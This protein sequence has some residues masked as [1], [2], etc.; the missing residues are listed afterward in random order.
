MP[1][2]PWGISAGSAN[3]VFH[4]VE[5]LLLASPLA[6]FLGL[7]Y[8]RATVV[9][10][11]VVL[12]LVTPVP[13]MLQTRAIAVEV[14]GRTGHVLWNMRVDFLALFIDR[15]RCNTCR[16]KTGAN[17]WTTGTA[18]ALFSTAYLK[19][20]HSQRNTRDVIRRFG[21]LKALTERQAHAAPTRF[22]RLFELLGA[23]VFFMALEH[24]VR[25][26]HLALFLSLLFPP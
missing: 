3:R 2:P 7:E 9:R 24:G 1:Y 22:A 20:K 8:F 26:S 16:P 4:T 10:P 21:L 11:V 15:G 23:T 19:H 6:V 18:C 13:L 25:R 17:A 12:L 14:P 5:C